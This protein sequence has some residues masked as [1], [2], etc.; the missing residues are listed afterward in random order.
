[1]KY[2]IEL[3]ENQARVVQNALESYLRLRMGQFFDYADEIAHAG[4]E[5]DKENP[6]NSELFNDYINR[7]N[8]A[9]EIFNHAFRI[10]QPGLQQKTNDMLVSEDIWRAIRYKRWQDREE[11]KPHNTVDAYP[12][13]RF[14]NEPLP[15]IEVVD[16]HERENS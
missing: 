15:K 7:R 11:P 8:E 4:Y 2:R 10:A 5:Y 1:M 9:E 6:N 13:M 14:S 3:T 12:P 16:E